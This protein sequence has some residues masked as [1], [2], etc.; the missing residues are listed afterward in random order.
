MA[1]SKMHPVKKKKVPSLPMAFNGV[2]EKVD[3][4]KSAKQVER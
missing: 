3:G 1:L 4:H 2:G